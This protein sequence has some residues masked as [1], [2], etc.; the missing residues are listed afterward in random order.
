MQE[1]NLKILGENLIASQS[2][3][4]EKIKETSEK[5]IT[6]LSDQLLKKYPN[7]KTLKEFPLITFKL[8]DDENIAIIIP[9]IVNYDDTVTLLDSNGKITQFDSIIDYSLSEYLSIA[10][11]Q[12]KGNI[13]TVNVL[14]DTK[15]KKI[16]TASSAIEGKG[17]IDINLL[18]KH[19]VY[20]YLKD[21][22]IGDYQ[23]INI[24]KNK[25]MHNDY[26]LD[27]QKIDSKE[28]FKQVVGNSKL[29]DLIKYYKLKTKFQITGEKQNFIDDEGNPKTKVII[30]DL[31]FDDSNLSDIQ[32]F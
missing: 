15:N 18:K 31:L 4:K 16:K 7:L 25:T 17:N 26:I 8:L 5:E 9:K 21:I 23:V 29:N 14:A 27:L 12:I 24:Y 13:F 19:F 11:V 32:L 3:F 20:S 22:E 2:N 6:L 1:I 28:I 10:N 30:K